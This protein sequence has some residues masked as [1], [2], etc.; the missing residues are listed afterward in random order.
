MTTD[1]VGGVWTY[2]L[3]LADALAERDVEVTLAV[4]GDPTPG[5]RDELR[6]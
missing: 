5:Q 6:R 3:E 4:Q 1:T 2:A